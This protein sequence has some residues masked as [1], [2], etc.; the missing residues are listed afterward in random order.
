MA[1]YINKECKN[2]HHCYDGYVNTLAFCF[3]LQKFQMKAV[4]TER[5]RSTLHYN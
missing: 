4:L 5:L 3:L 1:K 2:V